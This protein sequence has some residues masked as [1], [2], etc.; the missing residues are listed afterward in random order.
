MSFLVPRINKR[1]VSFD[2]SGDFNV[3]R[4]CDWTAFGRHSNNQARF[5]RPSSQTGSCHWHCVVIFYY[6]SKITED[7]N[8]ESWYNP[9]I[10]EKLL[11]TSSYKIFYVVNTIFVLFAPDEKKRI[12]DHW[13]HITSSV[14]KTPKKKIIENRLDKFYVIFADYL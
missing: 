9:D 14:K 6:S 13:Q 3:G 11:P 5:E 4:R 8:Q 2:H 1:Q 10:I 12:P 7:R